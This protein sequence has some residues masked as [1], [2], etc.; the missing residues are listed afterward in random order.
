MDVTQRNNLFKLIDDACTNEQIKKLLKIKK[1]DDNKIRVSGPSDSLITQLREGLSRGT[2]GL[3]DLQ[4][5]LARGEE[6]GRQH[7]FFYKPRPQVLNHYEDPYKVAAKLFGKVSKMNFPQIHLQP[8]EPVWADFRAERLD[9][10][11]KL[12]WVAKFYVGREVEHLQ[13]EKTEEKELG[14]GSIRVTRTS[15]RRWVRLVLLVKW[16]PWGM[17]EIRVPTGTSESR[18]TCLDEREV[19]WNQI[20]NAV[21]PT[22]FNPWKLEPAMKILVEEAK[23]SSAKHRVASTLAKDG[24]N[25]ALLS[26]AVEGQSLFDSVAHQKSVNAYHEVARLDVYWLPWEH[27]PFASEVR[28]QIGVYEPNGIRVGE[29]ISPETLDYVVN[30]LRDA[31]SK[32][33][34]A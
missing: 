29:K 9:G 15:I 12:G 22:H 14:D 10:V 28:S 8:K 21:D 6:N 25:S 33:D 27:A 5:L 20:A 13:P 17:L 30:R 23:K 26:P 19:V 2:I 31:Q 18:K 7:I 16:R 32:A 1:D 11:D 3:M 24:Q 4:L 34:A